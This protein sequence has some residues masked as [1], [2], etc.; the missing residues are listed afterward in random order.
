MKTWRDLKQAQQEGEAS[1][2]APPEDEWAWMLA[3]DTPRPPIDNHKRLRMKSFEEIVRE[4][5]DNDTD[6]D[7]EW[8]KN[9]KLCIRWH[10][11]PW[12]HFVYHRAQRS[13]TQGTQQ[14]QQGG[15]GAAS[16]ARDFEPAPD[17]D[18]QETDG[19]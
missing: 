10:T 12:E 16:E 7:P 15:T 9:C 8:R 18:G 5:L 1:V 13:N 2:S 17:K 3:P 6:E 11:S 4:A 14:N 19:H